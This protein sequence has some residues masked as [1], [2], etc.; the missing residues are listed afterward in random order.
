MSLKS[1]GQI[2]IHLNERIFNKPIEISG[3]KI[4]SL[5]RTGTRNLPGNE[6]GIKVTSPF[7]L[8]NNE[9]SRSVYLDHVSF[10]NKFSL[11]KSVFHKGV[12]LL[13]DTFHNSV[14]FSRNHFIEHPSLS[15]VEFIK[16]SNFRYS[17]FDSD[18]WFQNSNFWG[19]ANFSFT[20]FNSVKFHDD[21]FTNVRFDQLTFN[22]EASFYK[23]FFKSTSDFS[24]IKIKKDLQFTMSTFQ[25]SLLLIGLKMRD[26]ANIDF[27]RTNLPH[28][29]DFS[30]NPFFKNIVDLEKANFE[31]LEY[32]SDK[33]RKWHYLN[34][35]RADVSKFK[36]DYEHFRLCFYSY[37]RFD[38]SF[39]KYFLD[40]TLSKKDV[41]YIVSYLWDKKEFRKYIYQ[42]FPH[43]KYSSSDNFFRTFSSKLKSF[44]NTDIC[45]NKTVLQD[46]VIHA[47]VNLNRETDEDQDF[48]PF[49]VGILPGILPED[50]I[51]S[52]YEKALNNFNASGQKLSYKKLDIEYH[53]FL[54]GSFILPHIWNCY[55]YHKEWVFYWAF[56]IFLPLFTLFTFFFLPFL[57][58]NVYNLTFFTANEVRLRSS[59][60]EKKYYYDESGITE[61][62]NPTF[63]KRYFSR[64]WY[65]F[66][67]TGVIFFL[68]SLKI[69]NF[70][71]D[72]RFKNIMGSFY[73]IVVYTIG[74]IC[75][76]Y[77][78]N[79]ALQK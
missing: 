65:S 49:F 7:I 9:F 46:R 5:S 41:N 59:K 78:A 4:D 20:E 26:S 72:K 3:K 79:F 61:Q 2:F 55:G 73:V 25:E 47:Y 33:S 51:I 34:L 15:N 32:Y 31:R 22:K 19:L 39:Q 8:T 16:Q 27:E 76:A 62:K 66:V 70:K 57:Q 35:Y 24:E 23:C 42:I 71:F 38:T 63:V 75:I 29:L 40:D 52:L 53:D 43:T 17:K 13:W 77:M 18:T 68:F 30:F 10:E 64:L 6:L 11:S 67:Y 37:E 21:T 1:N 28:L 74:I 69:E 44:W 48:S 54:N 58:N 45:H 60:I 14:D 56:L 50:E 12:D 36:F